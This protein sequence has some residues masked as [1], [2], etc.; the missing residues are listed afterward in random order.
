MAAFKGS[1]NGPIHDH[2]ELSKAAPMGP[3]IINGSF[4][5]Q[6]TWAHPSSSGAFKG[7]SNGPIHRHRELSKEAQMGPFVIIGSFQ[8]QL[9]WAH[10]SSLGAFKGSS[11]GP[12][13]HHRV[14]IPSM[15]GPTWCRVAYRL[16]GSDCPIVVSRDLSHS[17]VVSAYSSCVV[18]LCLAAR[19]GLH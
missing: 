16:L 14:K 8:R 6:L 17:H 5:T 18:S 19:H 7:S 13:H 10:P 15:V 9:K 2:R 4:Q 3:S 12:I 11:N 1:S